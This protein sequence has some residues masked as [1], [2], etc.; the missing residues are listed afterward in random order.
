MIHET[1]LEKILEHCPK[2]IAENALRKN[3]MP[4][5]EFFEWMVARL[6]KV[7]KAN[8]VK[9]NIIELMQ[10]REKAKDK[11]IHKF[12]DHNFGD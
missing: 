1:K 6:Y 7:D 8:R 12:F 3:G 9:G 10:I 4:T 5:K 11:R 2:S